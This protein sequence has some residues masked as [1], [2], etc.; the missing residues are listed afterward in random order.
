MVAKK[1]KAA[2]AKVAKAPA[3]ES[4]EIVFADPTE[5]A[6]FHQGLNAKRSAIAKEDAPHADGPLLKAWLKGWNLNG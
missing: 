4:G 1:A 2:P 5:E 3:P 6:A